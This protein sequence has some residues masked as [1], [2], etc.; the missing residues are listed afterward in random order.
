MHHQFVF[1][2]NPEQIQGSRICFDAF[3]SRHINVLRLQKG[4]EIRVVDGKGR[5]FTVQLDSYC[6]N[7]WRGFIHD[8]RIHESSAPAPLSLALPCLKGEHWGIALEA[9]CEIGIH[10]I[11][12]VDYQNSAVHWTEARL[13][14]ARRKALEALKQSGGSH[15]THVSGPFSL[16][17][18]ITGWKSAI[19]VAD[20]SGGECESVP[21]SALL[22][23]GPE[24]GLHE[25]EI[26]ALK[27][28]KSVFIRFGDRRLRS[29]ISAIVAVSQMILKM[30]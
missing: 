15:L 10:E 5:L 26:E 22:I 17:E 4:A 28:R 12:L 9:A 16:T 20:S 8:S 3:E 29:E 13:E 11:F 1:Y 6:D 24:A 18:L 7:Q 21:E 25:Q 23:I 2:A 30:K 19:L 27:K 14:K